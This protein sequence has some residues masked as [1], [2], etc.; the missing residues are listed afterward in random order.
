MHFF[1]LL[2]RSSRQFRDILGRNIFPPPL[3]SPPL[4]HPAK[5]TTIYLEFGKFNREHADIFFFSLF[6]SLL[7]EIFMFK[8]FIRKLMKNN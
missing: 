2:R 4:P 1:F 7:A 6:F 8:I 5:C 3:P